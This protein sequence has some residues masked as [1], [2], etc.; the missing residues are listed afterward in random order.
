MHVG[1]R[2]VADHFWYRCLLGLLS[3]VTGGLSTYVQEPLAISRRG[4]TGRDLTF[5]R[6]IKSRLPFAG[7]IRSSPFSTRFQGKG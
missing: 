2:I 3:S 5:K 4:C 7:I 1:L 6:R